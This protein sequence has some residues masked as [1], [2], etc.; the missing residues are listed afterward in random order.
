MA[1]IAGLGSQWLG[2]QSSIRARLARNSAWALAGNGF[3][4]AASL[5]S[6]IVMGRLLGVH[7]F[8]QLAL[9]QVT[10][11]LLG[12][13]GEAG[14]SLTTTKFTGQWRSSDP[15]RAGNLLSWASRLTLLLALAMSVLLAAAGPSLLGP[16][17]AAAIAAGCVLLI[18]DMMNKLQQGALAGL[19]AFGASARIHAVRGALVLPLVWM[20]ASRWGLAGGVAA[21]ALASGAGFLTGRFIL[22]RECRVRAIPLGWQGTREPGIART[23]AALWGSLVLASV[24][25]WLASFLLTRAPGGVAELGLFNAADKWKS[26]MV[27]LPNVLFQV[28]LPMLS[29]SHAAGDQRA[30]SRI[31][32]AAMAA[33][34]GTTGAVALAIGLW[35]ELFM[36]SFGPGF[37][38][39]ASVLALGGVCAVATGIHVVASGALWAIGRPGQ[40]LRMDAIKT[41]VLLAPCAA[42]MI[43]TA[44]DLMLAYLASFALGS[45]LVLISVRRQ[46]GSSRTV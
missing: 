28:V 39:G 26:A 21:L 11:L 17:A 36:S 18:F 30:C 13:I 15:A 40:M 2:A 25:T 41:A 9:I 37:S 34:I 4:Q 7:D 5:A 8:G 44:F 32:S 20:G 3:S 45:L 24:S 38:A 43:V 35:P 29:H 1:A 33:V 27:F 23:S 42:G 6:A 16:G 46:L 22:R 31:L 10:L 14:L 12:N 19:E